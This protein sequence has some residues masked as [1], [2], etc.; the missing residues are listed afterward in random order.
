MTG[1][2]VG[3]A[4]K[5]QGVTPM[6]ALDKIDYQRIVVSAIGAL[7]LSTACIVGAVGPAQAA[8]IAPA[9]QTVR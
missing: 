1:G 6:F 3:P 7:I 9:V 4:T 5:V 2:N 8:S